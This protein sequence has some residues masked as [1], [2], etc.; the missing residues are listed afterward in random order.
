MAQ[1]AI[2]GVT[3]A[4]T[5]FTTLSTAAIGAEISASPEQLARYGIA[6][7]EVREAREEA[8][9]LLPAVVVPPNNSRM[10]VTAPFAGTVRSVAVLPGS[11]VTKGDALATIVSRELVEAT[12]QLRQAEAELAAS[13][14]VAERYRKLAEQRIAAPT[15][16]DETEAQAERLR[17]VVEEHKRLLAIGGIKIE[18][19]G[20]YVLTAPAD[21][22]VVE[23]EIGPGAQITSMSAVLKL[24]TSDRLWVEAQ[25]PAFLVGRVQPGDGIRI[26]DG[27]AGRVLAVSHTIDPATR[28]AKLV[29]ELPPGSGLLAGQ[30]L[31]ISIVRPATT[32]VLE[33]PT[34]SLAYVAGKPT[35]FVRTE[36]GFV[37]STVTL[38]GQS[39]EN[40]S[41]AGDL[42]PGQ[43]VA[44]SGIAVLENMIGAE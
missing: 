15:R 31:T 30:M 23:A 24:D 16:A 13:T 18:A 17:A 40:A 35:V 19:D 7:A 25:L 29:G 4:L 33:V 12:S 1:A 37:A 6:L 42:R 2:G 5:L 9:V 32:G 26:G 44:T 28:S 34:R 14:A 43:Q 22:R 11:A 36:Q 41:I 39:L 3:L 10:A 27:I 21:G 20:S 8:L 38:R